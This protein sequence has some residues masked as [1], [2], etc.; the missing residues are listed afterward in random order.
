MGLTDFRALTFDCYGTLIDWETGMLAGLERLAA[1]SPRT[2]PRAEILE[3]YAAHESHQER[4]SPT[5]KYST[6]LAVI[7]KR[8]AENWE[9]QVTWEEC[10]GF[11]RSLRDWPAFPDSVAALKYLK[12]HYRLYV[13]SNV[14]N[15]GF[16][17]TSRKL[18][19]QFDGV[20]TAEDIGSYKPDPMNFQY[21]LERLADQG[22]RKDQI[23]HVAQSLF[24]DHAPA[25]DIGVASCWIDRQRT[26][27]G[28]GAT[29]RPATMPRYNFH[30]RSMAE[31]VEAHRNELSG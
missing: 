1:R 24:H 26:R 22:L 25:N 16:S 30:F 31:F 27:H 2:R 6:L 15:E 3:A 13:L 20:M 5:L 7:Y 29:Q 17:H 21:M 9:T 18:E 8:M 4:Y 23:L 11:G 14:D 28:F 12:S 10:V 19:V